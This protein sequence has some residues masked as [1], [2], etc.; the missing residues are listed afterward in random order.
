MDLF[1]K[2]KRMLIIY[3]SPNEHRSTRMLLNAFDEHFKND[4]SWMVDE[5]NA[6]DMNAKPCTACGECKEKEKCRF[7]DLNSWDKALRK[8]DLLVIASPVYNYSF[9]APFKA[10]LDRTQRYYEAKLTLGVPAPLEKDREAVLLVTSGSKE[11]YGVEVMKNQL[12]RAFTVMNT[13]LAGVVANFSTDKSMEIQ[14]DV[15]ERVSSL[16]LELID[17]S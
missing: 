9:P 3:C 16:A 6:Y 13:H 7:G 12:E 17:K 11:D 2:K 4:E 5:F 1:K 10:I 14:G 15:I 8:S